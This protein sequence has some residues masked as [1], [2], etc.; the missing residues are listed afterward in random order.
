MCLI[1]SRRLVRLS[2]FSSKI[3]ENMW[4]SERNKLWIDT[5][6]EQV[7]TKITSLSLVAALAI[8]KNSSARCRYRNESICFDDQN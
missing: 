4:V 1:T 7:E 5:E 2:P 8:D 3:S 6:L